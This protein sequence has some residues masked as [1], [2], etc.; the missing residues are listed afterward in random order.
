MAQGF[1]GRAAAYDQG[2]TAAADDPAVLDAALAR[3]VY[4]TVQATPEQLAAMRR[5]L[6][7]QDAALA[8]QPIAALMAGEVRFLPPPAA[9]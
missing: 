3:N 1:Y 7:A 5:Y 4:G 2:L 8:R 9:P 6:M